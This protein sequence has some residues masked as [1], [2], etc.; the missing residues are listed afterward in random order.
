M[1]HIVEYIVK[2]SR[3]R[4]PIIVLSGIASYFH[5]YF[6]TSSDIQH[7][8]LSL[9]AIFT[10]ALEEPLFTESTTLWVPIFPS[11]EVLEPLKLHDIKQNV[12]FTHILEDS[13]P[14]I[15]KLW[16]DKL[17]VVQCD[18]LTPGS[19]NH[20]LFL[21]WALRREHT[22]QTLSEEILKHL[23]SITSPLFSPDLF[24]SL[25]NLSKFC[26]LLDSE[27]T[28]PTTANSLYRSKQFLDSISDQKWYNLLHPQE[29]PILNDLLVHFFSKSRQTYL[30]LDK[31]LLSPEA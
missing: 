27:I 16:M 28:Q 29:E 10:H 20:I 6:K 21:S 17:Q 9:P 22:S 13:L 1:A 4:K 8:E 23:V 24:L 15:D 3:P 25:D 2:G 26:Y 30:F 31:F 12:I 5:S 7:S 11:L 18:S 14:E 19:K